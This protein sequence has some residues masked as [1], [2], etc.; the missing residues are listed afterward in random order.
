VP[1]QEDRFAGLLGAHFV[2][3][4][5]D[6]VGE[7][8]EAGH[9]DAVAFGFAVAVVV[10]AVDGVAFGHEMVD[11]VHVAAAVFGQAVEDQQHGFGV[12]IGQP[13]LLVGVCVVC[14]VEESFFVFHGGSP[15]A[16]G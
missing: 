1:D 5:F 4:A 9:E 14:A 12:A 15:R 2:E 3:V 7:L 10:K 8:L 13:G 16:G 11:D 6:R